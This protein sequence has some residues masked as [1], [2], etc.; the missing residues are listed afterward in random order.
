MSLSGDA[1]TCF[2]SPLEFFCFPNTSCGFTTSL[3]RKNELPSLE[4]FNSPVSNMVRISSFFLISSC[5]SSQSRNTPLDNFIPKKLAWR[6]C[7]SSGFIG[8]SMPPLMCFDAAA[9]AIVS[10]WSSDAAPTVATTWSCKN[11][12]VT[13]PPAA[14]AVL[15]SETTSIFSGA[16]NIFSFS[17]S[18]ALGVTIFPD[19]WRIMDCPRSANKSMLTRPAQN[20]G[21][22][23]FSRTCK[24]RIA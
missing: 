1:A 6:S 10:V 19:T 13:S 12:G 11:V 5:P 20:K 4:N 16:R 23:P 3:S 9:T 7:R 18:S 21:A 2:S 22:V 8:P 24:R 15:E 17:C 14:T